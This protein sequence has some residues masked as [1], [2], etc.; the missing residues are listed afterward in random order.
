MAITVVSSR[1][2]QMVLK[3][4]SGSFVSGAFASSD[5]IPVEISVDFAPEIEKYEIDVASDKLWKNEGLTGGAKNKATAKTFLCGSQPTSTTVW[6]PIYG[7]MDTIFK[8]SSLSALPLTRIEVTA[9]NLLI[10][11]GHNTFRKMKS[12]DKV[13]A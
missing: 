4:D 1:I 2:K 7:Y 13:Y 9:Q 11:R 10:K 8:A 6:T 12:A 5:A 3:A